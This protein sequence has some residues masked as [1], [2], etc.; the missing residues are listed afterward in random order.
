METKTDEIRALE[1]KIKELYTEYAETRIIS[2]SDPGPILARRSIQRQINRL[3]A[4]LLELQ[5]A[6]KKMD[7][8]GVKAH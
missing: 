4:Q 6:A 3:E 5:A 1:A 8:A 7:K 2:Q